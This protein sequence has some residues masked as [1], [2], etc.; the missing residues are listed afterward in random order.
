MGYD[1]RVSFETTIREGVS[2]KTVEAALRPLLDDANTVLRTREDSMATRMVSLEDG[3]LVVSVDYNVGHSFWAEIFL[4]LVHDV[5]KL[6]AEPFEAI[7]EN[8]D[9]GDADERYLSMVAGPAHLLPDYK[10]RAARDDLRIHDIVLP[11]A[12]RGWPLE[13]LETRT[14]MTIAM[15]PNGG[16]H[17]DAVS[18]VSVDLDGLDLDAARR[19]RIAK[20]SVLLAREIA[21]DELTLHPRPG[22]GA[23]ERALD[24]IGKTLGEIVAYDRR[25]NEEPARSPEGSDYNALLEIATRQIAEIHGEALARA[26]RRAGEAAEVEDTNEPASAPRG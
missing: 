11:P 24:G 25:M 13:D 26:D 7:L 18:R 16:D 1:A 19:S 12:T 3:L 15:F 8:Q 23:A 4:P 21:G 17:K 9:T 20:L 6:A 22:Y 10:S 5:G 2:R 14:C